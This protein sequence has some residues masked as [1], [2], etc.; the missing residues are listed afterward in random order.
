MNDATAR[1]G[2]AGQ[3]AALPGLAG[4]TSKI[5]ELLDHCRTLRMSG[6]TKLNLADQ[7]NEEHA[8]PGLHQWLAMQISKLPGISPETP[9]L[10]LGCG[11]GSWLRRLADAGYRDLVGVDSERETHFA[12]AEAV[13]FVKGNL[14]DEDLD[15][16]DRKF[17]LIT[18]I[19][20]IEHL[21]RPERL[22]DHALRYLDKT[23]WMLITTPNIYSIRVR[24]RFLLEGEMLWFDKYANDHHLHPVLLGPLN[25]VVLEPRDL[26][27]VE[28]RTYPENG[29]SPDGRRWSARLFDR[30]IATVLPNDL[31]G[32]AL[33]LLVRRRTVNDFETARENRRH[34]G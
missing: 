30:I 3:Q 28:I 17:G 16:G 25:R 12:G 13:N 8:W 26:A 18:A 9:V 24:M 10:D 20:V 2:E 29:A 27:I 11:T 34:R 4:R 31:R 23:G 6:M 19:E 32:D 14:N 33:C 22:F 15:L 5:R 1:L 21:A 7:L